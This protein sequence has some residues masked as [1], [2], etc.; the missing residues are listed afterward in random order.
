MHCVS[1][2]LEKAIDIAEKNKDF[3]YLIEHYWW[4]KGFEDYSTEDYKKKLK[5]LFDEKRFELSGVHSGIHTHWMSGE[6]L[7]RQ[8]YFSQI[9]T[10]KKWNIKPQSVVF[11]DISGVNWSCVSLFREGGI[12]Y[13][14]ILENIGFRKKNKENFPKFF[15]W[16]ATNKKDKLICWTQKGYRDI[17]IRTVWM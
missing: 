1:D 15:W 16:I 3:K 10:L 14:S 5:K 8:E 9:E 6:L 4:L 7:A 17:R 11:A 13:L 2:Y 12:K